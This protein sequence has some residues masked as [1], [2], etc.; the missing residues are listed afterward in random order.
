[1]LRKGTKQVKKWSG[2]GERRNISIRQA[3]GVLLTVVY[4]A[5]KEAL[6]R[7]ISARQATANERRIYEQNF[8]PS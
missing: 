7:I 2:P 3:H 6:Y 4:S 1:M 8:I 5:P